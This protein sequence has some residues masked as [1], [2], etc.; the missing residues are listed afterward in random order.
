M[1][2]L[3][4]GDPCIFGRGGEECEV[5]RAH[6]IPY[7]IVP[8]ITA[9][10]GATAYAGIPLTHRA[11]ASSV[12]LVTGHAMSGT[13]QPVH[14]EYLAKGVDTLVFYMGI[15]NVAQIAS[16]LLKHGCPSDTPAA[17]IERGT[18]PQQRTCV[19]T[20]ASLVETCNTEQITPPGIIIIGEVVRL[21]DKLQWFK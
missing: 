9:G 4:G 6:D 20:L 19:T 2:R 1:V 7:E 10:L 15:S 3:K 11:L 13:G 17:L 16:E 21:R 12:A 5:L 18:T 8:G 14:W